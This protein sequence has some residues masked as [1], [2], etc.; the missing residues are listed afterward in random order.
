MRLITNFFSWSRWICILVSHTATA[1]RKAAWTT[2]TLA[3]GQSGLYVARRK[4][5]DQ[6]FCEL[7]P[8]MLG[9]IIVR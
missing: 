7:H 4:G 9:R 6:Y 5:E 8:T 1:M 3:Q 2:G